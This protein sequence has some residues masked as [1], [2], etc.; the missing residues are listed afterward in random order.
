[1]IRL[2][3]TLLALMT[4]LSAENAGAETRLTAALRGSSA[5]VQLLRGGE[6]AVANAQ[7]ARHAPAQPANP[8][9]SLGM[10]PMVFPAPLPALA[11]TVPVLTPVDRAHE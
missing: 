6:A 4:G 9:A 7:A 2:I 1:M 11:A 10:A 3:L 8:L 5:V